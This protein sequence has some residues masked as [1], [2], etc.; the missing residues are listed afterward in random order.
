MKLSKKIIVYLIVVISAVNISFAAEISTE[1]KLQ[2]NKGVDMYRVGRYEEAIDAFEKA[3]ELDPDYI[4]AYYNLGSILEF[5]KQDDAAL[6]VFKQIILRKPTDYESVYK[7][8][9]LSVKLG[10]QEQ[11]KSYLSLIPQTSIVN[12][13]AQELAASMNTDMQT[14]KIEQKEAAEQSQKISQSNGVY[15]NLGSPTGMITDKNGNLYVAGFSDNAIVKISPD[16]NRRL[17][18]KDS[19]LNGPIGLEIDSAGNIYVAN[20]N[21]NN[22]LKISSTGAISVLIA[23]IPKPYALHIADGLLFISAQGSNSVIRYKL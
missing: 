22:V 13:K 3:V 10:Q 23:N 7:A 21:A 19:R 12:S 14:I 16:G 15:E 9:A 17:F 20:Y 1:A 8:A 6:A 4:D 11:A 18:V 2:Y 5:I